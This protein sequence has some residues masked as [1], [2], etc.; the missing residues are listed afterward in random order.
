MTAEEEEEEEEECGFI[1]FVT[2]LMILTDILVYI[3]ITVIK[4]LRCW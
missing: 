3:R 2:R 1:N 4:Y